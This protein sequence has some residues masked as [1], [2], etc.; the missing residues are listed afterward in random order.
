MKHVICQASLALVLLV[1][2]SAMA[3]STPDQ[4]SLSGLHIENT[5]NGLSAITGNAHNDTT[6]LLKHVFVKFNLY[7]GDTI[8]GETID[9]GE[10]IGPG[11]NWK[12]HAL[13]D[14]LKG[15]PDRFKVTE[16]Q[17]MN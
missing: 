8:I 2:A 5:A 13:I 11:E 12:V 7:Q 17:V 16:I 4:V 1:S 15:I 9:V 6:A 10:N 3:A 14:T